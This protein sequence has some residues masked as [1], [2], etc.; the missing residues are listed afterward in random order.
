MLYE[1]T[2]YYNIINSNLKHSQISNRFKEIYGVGAVGPGI[3]DLNCR[4]SRSL[5]CIDCGSTDFAP[6]DTRSVNRM[7]PNC[8]NCL[9]SH[10]LLICPEIY[11]RSAYENGPD[12]YRNTNLQ[13]EDSEFLSCRSKTRYDCLCVLD[14]WLFFTIN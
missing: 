8:P 13:D 2:Q 1:I 9:S 11:C 12:M 6:T 14:F 4:S 10:Y 7:C 5:V 3:S